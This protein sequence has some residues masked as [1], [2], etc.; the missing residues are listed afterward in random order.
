MRPMWLY[1]GLPEFKT[2][3]KKQYGYTG[4]FKSDCGFLFFSM[5]GKWEIGCH[6]FVL[7][8]LINVI[9]LYN[10]F[11]LLPIPVSAGFVV[12]NR[13]IPT[14]FV[15]RGLHMIDGKR[16]KKGDKDWVGVGSGWGEKIEI[17]YTQ[18]LSSQFCCA[19]KR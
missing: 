9:I 12:N 16:E 19:R 13:N 2:K 1:L 3:D 8:S 7:S 17:K 14:N 18:F 10:H 5:W 4:F 15:K 11:W 6:F